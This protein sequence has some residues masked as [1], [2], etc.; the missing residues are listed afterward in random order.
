[1]RK[2]LMILATL[3]MTAFLAGCNLDVGCLMSVCP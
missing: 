3:A 1:M 2:T